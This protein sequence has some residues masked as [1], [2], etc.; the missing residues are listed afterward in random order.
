MK[1]LIWLKYVMGVKR[2]LNMIVRKV[3]VVVWLIKI[4]RLFWI[5]NK[6]FFWGVGGML[7]VIF[8]R[9]FDLCL[10]ERK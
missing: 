2:I 4:V 6:D 9:G 10:Y 8:N 7:F 3:E 1:Y 5:E